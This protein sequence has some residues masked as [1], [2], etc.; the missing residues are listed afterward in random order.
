MNTVS[1]K[2]DI[3]MKFGYKNGDI[4]DKNILLRHIV[5]EL[6]QP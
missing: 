3:Q 4:N 5:G 6:G 1:V 2:R